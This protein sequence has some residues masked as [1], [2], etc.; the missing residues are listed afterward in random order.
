MSR[1]NASDS[2][3]MSLTVRHS[4][5]SCPKQIGRLFCRAAFFIVLTNSSYPSLL[6]KK[7]LL[8]NHLLLFSIAFILIPCALSQ[9]RLLH[10]YRI[11]F[12]SDKDPMYQTNIT[13]SIF[14]THHLTTLY[15]IN[16][17]Y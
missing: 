9:R 17:F 6:G 4:G 2:C 5:S 15:S 12:K 14:T 3:L 1:L 13:I 11:I 10:F 7:G 16:N 8:S